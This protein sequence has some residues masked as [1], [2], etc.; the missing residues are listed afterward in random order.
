MEILVCIK[1]VPDDSVE[2]SL[3]KETNMPNLSGITKIVNAFDTY[4]LEMA[5]RLKEQVGG[6]VTV[7]SIGDE[8]VK[9]SLKNCLAVG[10]DRAYLLKNDDFEKLD[11]S[12]VAKLLIKGKEEIEKSLDK[13][14]DIVFCGKE[15]TDYATSQVGLFIGDDLNIPVVA[16]I[17]EIEVDGTIGKANQETE[18]GY[19][20]F[21]FSLPA[22]VTV[23][24]PNYE[25]RYPTIK[26]K[27]AARKKPI[28]ELTIES[29][30]E[31]KIEV[32]S[33]FE[34]A[35]RKAGVKIKAEVV[36]DAVSEAMKLIAEAKVL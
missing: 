27:M 14:F 29:D 28:Q 19:N 32:I 7:L 23:Q 1:Q 10:A 4:S 30:V 11:P 35:K 17:V 16:N 2:V 20:S 12:G 15:T 25:P 5:T 13:K 31:S 26:T 22:V 34:P 8:S 6:E 3:N 33:I 18:E 36:E 24:K 21:E 9:N